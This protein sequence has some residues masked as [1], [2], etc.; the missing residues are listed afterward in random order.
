[1]P[2]TSEK[3]TRGSDWSF[4]MVWKCSAASTPPAPSSQAPGQ[5]DTPHHMT[6]TQA[7]SS[8]REPHLQAPR[9]A[10]AVW[11]AATGSCER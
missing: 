3:A 11:A 7:D 5:L 4:F 9:E 2:L 10:A 8:A 1:M 6:P